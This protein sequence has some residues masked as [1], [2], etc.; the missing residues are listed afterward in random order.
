MSDPVITR[1]RPLLG[2]GLRTLR[3]GI[4]TLLVVIGLW[5]G[6]I[7]V[8]GVSPFLAKTP[9]DVVDWLFVADGA[10]ENR[11][12]VLTRLGETLVDASVGFVLGLFVASVVAV[13]FSLFRGIEH[14][15]MPLAL[16]LRSIPLVAI[17]PIII[18]IFGR[19]VTTTAV[20]GAIVVLFPALV[21]IAFGLRAS[22]PQTADVVAVYGGNRLTVLRLVAFPSSL[23][24]FFAAVRVAVPGAITGAML[25]EWLATS[26]GLGSSIVIAVAQVKNFEVW[27]SVV[28]IT[29][30]SIVLYGVVQLIENVVLSRMGMSQ[31]TAGSAGA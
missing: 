3:T 15:L 25:A 2:P 4:I 7:A 8:F 19:D 11:Q 30:T 24:A 26:R 16:L 13:L 27:S 22:S 12:G 23:P 6:L 5:Y 20:M 9:L 31:N 17:A 1:R 29:V 28:A 14:A 21:T 18:L 10:A